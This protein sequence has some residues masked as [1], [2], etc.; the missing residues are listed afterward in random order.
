M[1][2]NPNTGLS[3]EE[4]LRILSDP[5]MANNLDPLRPGH[6]MDPGQRGAMSVTVVVNGV[7]GKEVVDAL[8]QYVDENGPLSSSLVA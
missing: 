5:A 4:A 7:S 8:G 2:I 1:A 6:T 3:Q